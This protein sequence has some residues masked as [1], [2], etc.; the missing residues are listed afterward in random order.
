MRKSSWYIGFKTIFLQHLLTGVF[1]CAL[2][3]LCQNRQVIQPNHDLSLIVVTTMQS[4]IVS[5]YTSILHLFFPSALFLRALS[6]LE[7]QRAKK[8]SS[9]TSL[10]I[11]PRAWPCLNKADPYIEGMTV[12][13][14]V[15]VVVVGG[16]NAEQDQ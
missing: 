14:F 6:L 8:E 15:C 2:L 12:P 10:D 4:V 16:S 7:E 13:F 1:V 11:L 3:H 5:L 9:S